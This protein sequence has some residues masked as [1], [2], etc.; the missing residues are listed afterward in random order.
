MESNL[1]PSLSN[2]FSSSHANRRSNSRDSLRCSS[3]KDVHHKVAA[4]Q[5]AAAGHQAFPLARTPAGHTT[6]ISGD[7]NQPGTLSIQHPNSMFTPRGS[8]CV[9][10]RCKSIILGEKRL[11]VLPCGLK[12][13]VRSTVA[14]H[15][16]TAD[17][18][19]RFSSSK[20]QLLATA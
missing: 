6:V 8:L 15:A 14:H 7:R 11:H 18:T 16:S 12:S 10:L 19:Y 1:S 13:C 20:V 9:E 3:L 4:T 17:C 2:T 5:T